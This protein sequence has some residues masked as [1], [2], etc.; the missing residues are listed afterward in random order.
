MI[1]SDLWMKLQKLEA[2][3]HG[4]YIVDF[5]GGLCFTERNLA[6]IE[7]ELFNTKAVGIKMRAEFNNT[8]SVFCS[9][10]KAFV[11]F[12]PS[13]ADLFVMTVNGA[14]RNS[15]VYISVCESHVNLMSF[16]NIDS[17]RYIEAL[18]KNSQ[19][20]WHKKLFADG[21]SVHEVTSTPK[22]YMLEYS[23]YVSIL[24]EIASAEFFIGSDASR[25]QKF[26]EAIKN[27]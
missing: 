21:I 3:G 16:D 26:R 20:P 22:R 8:V 7:E 13:A 10:I 18:I 6:V 17:D 19:I 11:K 24:D 15:I 9:K 27:L 4:D 25:K 23:Y 2:A 12:H 5:A 14:E 1:L